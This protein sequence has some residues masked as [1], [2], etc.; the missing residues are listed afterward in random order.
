MEDV[1]IHVGLRGDG[2][3]PGASTTF[4][5]LSEGEQQLLCVMGMLR[6]TRGDETLFLLDE[7]DTHLD[8]RWKLDYLELLQREVGEA[9]ATS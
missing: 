9:S 4:T 5:E 8:P 1:R 6:F 2:S 3:T 7:P